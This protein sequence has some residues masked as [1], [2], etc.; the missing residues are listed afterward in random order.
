MD[1]FSIIKLK[2]EGNSNRQ[3]AKLLHIDRKTVAN[4]WN[5]YLDQKNKLQS[6][7]D[8]LKIKEI[9]EEI[10]SAPKYDVKARSKRKVTYELIK[11]INEILEE[12]KNKD[13]ILGPNKQKLT[14]KQ[15]YE[16]IKN[17]G[18]DIS[19][20]AVYLEIKKIK[21]TGKET[22]IRQEYEFGDRLEYDFGE[23]KLVIDGE[24]KKYYLA[25][26]SSPGANFRWC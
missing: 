23:V 7:S 12:E 5:D 4:Y 6:T 24:V 18:F 13:E 10:T 9:Q 25:V 19:H 22:F 16:Q 21:G 14:N 26:L 17:E 15:I 11:R 8:E 3:V 2:E 1:K 20:S